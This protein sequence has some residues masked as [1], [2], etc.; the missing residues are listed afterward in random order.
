MQGYK[1]YQYDD[2]HGFQFIRMTPERRK[3]PTRITDESINHLA[4]KVFRAGSDLGRVLVIPIPSVMRSAK[5]LLDTRPPFDGME[6][7]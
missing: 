5:C 7:E 6:I 1:F 2:F 3:D 4:R